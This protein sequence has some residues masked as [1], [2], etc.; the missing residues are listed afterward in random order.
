MP[1]LPENR[2]W[3][4]IG[5]D[6][7]GETNPSLPSPSGLGLSTRKSPLLFCAAFCQC[8]RTAGLFAL[9]RGWRCSGVRPF[10]C[11]QGLDVYKVASVIEAKTE[12]AIEIA[13]KEFK[14]ASNRKTHALRSNFSTS[15]LPRPV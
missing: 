4:G 9:V 3:E 5:R 7:P 11:C 1:A 15:G 6:E 14:L 13:S 10:A 12:E 2:D 8:L